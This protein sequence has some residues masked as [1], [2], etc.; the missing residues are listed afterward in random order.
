MRTGDLQRV[1]EQLRLAGSGLTD[2]QLLLRFLDGQEEGAFAA[3]VGRHGPMVLGVCRRVLGH[4]QDAEDAFQAAFLVLARKAA[5]VARR[6]A[7]GAWLY[8]V[9]YRAALAARDKA[10]RRRQWERQ[11]DEMPHPEVAPPD[12]DDWRPVLDRELAALPGRYRTA[13]V[14]CDLEGKT[15]REVARQLGLSEGTLSSHLT[16]GRRL[17][18]RRLARRGV[19]LSAGALATALAGEA[20]AA[21][22]GALAVAT[23]KGAVVAA[24]G[25]AGAATPAALLMREVLKAMW[26]TKLKACLAAALLLG[27]GG[28]MYQVGGQDV[29]E[30]GS[31]PPRPGMMRAPA[32]EPLTELDLLRR[33]VEILKLQMEVVQAELR[34]LKGQAGHETSKTMAPVPR[35]PSD[36]KVA[37]PKDGAPMHKP[38]P[39]MG[40]AARDTMQAGGKTAGPDKVAPPDEGA[41]HEVEAALKVFRMARASGDSDAT[42][43]AAAALDRA[44]RRLRASI[45]P[46][47]DGQKK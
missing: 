15:R 3:L 36:M 10:C 43:R 5:S 34:S 17:L 8:R 41:E 2:G 26:M 16:R 21:V 23:V 9:A 40:Q 33:E 30:K 1:L 37:P 14:L 18:A 27:V 42:R 6:E 31:A 25:Q 38:Y 7:L 44:L 11:V 32:G 45:A 4:A 12:A 22:P 39:Y 20:P 13:L 46:P 24:G 19:S 28:L 47:D 29:V 35:F